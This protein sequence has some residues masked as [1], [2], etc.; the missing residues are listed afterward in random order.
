MKVAVSQA[1]EV[2]H[3]FQAKDGPCPWEGRW[4]RLVG[5]PLLLLE[6]GLSLVFHACF[7]VRP[8][9]Q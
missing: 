9:P 8:G 4:S 3:S 5:E 2:G 7:P 1:D 6:L